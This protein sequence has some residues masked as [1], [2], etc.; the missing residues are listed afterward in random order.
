MTWS[1]PGVFQFKQLYGATELEAQ[2]VT[3]TFASKLHHS[4]PVTSFV[5]VRVGAPIADVSWEVLTA[6]AGRWTQLDTAHGQ[7]CHILD[8]FHG[9]YILTLLGFLVRFQG[10]LKDKLEYCL[11]TV[12]Q[13]QASSGSLSRPKFNILCVFSG[14][15]GADVG[16]EKHLSLKVSL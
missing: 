1:L 14:A 12:L 10:S 6:I 2:W 8:T 9:R 11:E 15:L 4:D 13:D 7:S 3:S 5:R 16:L